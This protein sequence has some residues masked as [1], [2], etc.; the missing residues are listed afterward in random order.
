[1]NIQY[2]SN[3]LLVRIQCAY[4]IK[5]IT[6]L[7]ERNKIIIKT[8]YALITAVIGYIKLFRTTLLYDLN[9]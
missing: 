3:L 6:V 7:D 2:A 9:L 1:M 8:L 4:S 5:I